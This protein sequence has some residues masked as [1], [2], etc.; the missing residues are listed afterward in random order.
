MIAAASSWTAH[1]IWN[2]GHRD[3]FLRQYETHHNRT[4]STVADLC[5]CPLKPLP[6]LS[7]L[8]STA[9]ETDPRRWP[10]NEYR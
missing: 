1:L 8:S 2:S 3:R 9:P 5:C 4:A 6:D 10:I 7:I